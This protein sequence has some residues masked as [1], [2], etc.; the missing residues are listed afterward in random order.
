[1]SLLCLQLYKIE[2]QDVHKMLQKIY[3][4]RSVIITYSH[5]SFTYSSRGH[6][7]VITFNLRN[8]L[9]R[10]RWETPQS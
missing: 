4:S 8:D 1:M 6:I 3:L 9:R 5:L 2:L 10:H 7:Q